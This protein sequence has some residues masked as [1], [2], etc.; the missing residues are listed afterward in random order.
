MEQDG[1][2]G[3]M[4]EIYDK[5][6]GASVEFLKMTIYYEDD[7]YY[8]IDPMESDYTTGNTKLPI[9]TYLVQTDSQERVQVGNTGVLKGVYN[10][11]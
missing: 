9:G 2:Q 5:D 6:G 10:Y 8:Y 1:E 7:D 4:K 3:F 11:Q